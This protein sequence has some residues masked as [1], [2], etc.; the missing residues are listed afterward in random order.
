V[1]AAAQL[2]V[3][4]QREPSFDLVEPGQPSTRAC[5]QRRSSHLC[6]VWPMLYWIG[7]DRA[8]QAL[9]QL[10]QQCPRRSNARRPGRCCPCPNCRFCGSDRHLKRAPSSPLRFVV[11]SPAHHES[12]T[13]AY[14]AEKE[15]EGDPADAIVWDE[16]AARTREEGLNVTLLT[17]RQYYPHAGCIGIGRL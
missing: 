7:I 13:A 1:G 14:R 2:F 9:S 4:Q 10:R 12:A 8:Q 16:L 6:S 11:S 3:G 17:S 5:S 15:A